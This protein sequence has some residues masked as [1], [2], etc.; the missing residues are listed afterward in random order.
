MDV[1]LVGA[2]LITGLVLLGYVVTL[3]ARLH[4]E[5]ERQ[6]A[7]QRELDPWRDGSGES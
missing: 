1:L 2:Y 5:I 4:R 7:L 3:R 6:L